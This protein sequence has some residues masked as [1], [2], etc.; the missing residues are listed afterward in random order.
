MKKTFAFAFVLA[1]LLVSTVSCTPIVRVAVQAATGTTI[2]SQSSFIGATMLLAF[3]C[4][5]TLIGII[6]LAKPLSADPATEGEPAARGAATAVN[7]SPL[8]IF[9]GI[10]MAHLLV[11]LWVARRSHDKNARLFGIARQLLNFQIT[12]TLFVVV[13]L[14]L[15]IAIVGILMLPLLLAFQLFVCV[16][17]A[18]HT[19]HGDTPRYPISLDLIR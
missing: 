10:P 12:W 9:V 13:A 16:R 1:G 19:W 7:L 15:S 17:A 11:P 2:A 4:L 5:C 18:W 8:L 14:L 6:I 3:A